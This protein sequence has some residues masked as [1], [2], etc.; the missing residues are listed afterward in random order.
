MLTQWLY[1]SI[2]GID[3][4]YPGTFWERLFG[5]LDW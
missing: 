3:I 5:K 4:D 1:K 2:A